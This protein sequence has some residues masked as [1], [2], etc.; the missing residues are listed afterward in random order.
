MTKVVSFIAGC[1]AGGAVVAVA[2]VLLFLLTRPSPVVVITNLDATPVPNVHI[3]T[4]VGESYPL[5]A[6]AGH[7]TR[8]VQISGGP[9]A[10]WVIAQF[11]AGGTKE[12]EKIYVTSS[13][14]VFTLIS[15]GSVAIAYEL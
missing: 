1:F 12:S 10:L 6:L 11:P 4:D 2:A 9:K 15:N 14:M 7:S 8:R 5:G 13:G 3:E